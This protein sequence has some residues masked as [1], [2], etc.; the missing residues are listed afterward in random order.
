M[1]AC[2]AYDEDVLRKNG[3][4][5]HGEGLQGPDT[6]TTMVRPKNGKAIW[7]PTVP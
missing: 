7:S 3:H 1:D 6:A 5:V 4:W 2:F